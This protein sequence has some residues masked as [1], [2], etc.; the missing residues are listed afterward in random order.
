MLP[1]LLL[2]LRSADFWLR[3]F[4]LGSPAKVSEVVRFRS[5]G[6]SLAVL[7][8][9]QRVSRDVDA[10]LDDDGWKAVACRGPDPQTSKGREKA[11]ADDT[12]QTSRT[13]DYTRPSWGRYA[14]VHLFARGMSE[15]CVF[16]GCGSSHVTFNLA[17]HRPADP[18]CRF[19]DLT[20][21]QLQPSSLNRFAPWR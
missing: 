10:G 20:T 6:D 12:A 18:G 17:F 14:W 2:I 19:S 4:G 8:G 7:H 1:L 5:M 13:V 3:K 9:D 21:R 16:S 15:G 11:I